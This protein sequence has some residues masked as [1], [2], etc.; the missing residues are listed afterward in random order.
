MREE[1]VN[2]ILETVVIDDNGITIRPSEKTNR[3][4][5][6]HQIYNCYCPYGSITSAK[7][8]LSMLNVYCTIR[9]KEYLCSVAINGED[10][11]R[12]KSALEFALKAVKNAPPVDAINYDE[13]KPVEHRMR[14]AFC[15]E[16]FC[17]SD[18]DLRKNRMYMKQAQA[19]NQA[20]F[21]EA[22]F[23]TR[24]MAQMNWDAGESYESKIV[25]YSRC[26]KCNSTN[27]VEITEQ[28]HEAKANET[29]DGTQTFSATDELKKFK[30]LLDIGIITQEEFDAKK[31]QLLG[32]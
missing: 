32:L 29:N 25:D 27:I 8:F 22:L 15:G 26:P 5:L 4:G 6:P 11:A 30:E 17:Y 12:M 9:G 24:I 14:C 19:A 20:A 21:T 18:D 31:K 16:I 10:K 13:E 28:E 23:G 2:K 3:N 1:F 7:L